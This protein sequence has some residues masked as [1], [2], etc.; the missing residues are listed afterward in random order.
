VP[1]DSEMELLNRWRSGDLEAGDA[2]FGL[3][4]PTMYR[5]FHNKVAGDVDDLVQKTFAACL[6]SKDAIRG[7]VRSYLFGVARNM[8]RQHYR[9]NRRTREQVDFAVDSVADVG[10][11][12]TQELAAKADRRLLLEALRTIPLDMQIAIELSYWE[13]VSGREL[14]SVLGVPEPTARTRLRAARKRLEAQL[15]KIA[16]SPALLATTL[17]SIERWSARIQEQLAS[18]PEAAR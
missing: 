16:Q 14:A 9:D 10:I 1:D 2:L 11:T 15:R 3:Y 13:G 8:L 12:P 17:E 18:D 4:F 5:F 6:D 7:S